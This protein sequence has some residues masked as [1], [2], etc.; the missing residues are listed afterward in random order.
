[1]ARN[2][3]L[4]PV[5]REYGPRQP[6]HS[7]TPFQSLAKPDR[8]RKCH[9]GKNPC[10]IGMSCKRCLAEGRRRPGGHCRTLSAPSGWSRELARLRHGPV[11]MSG[12]FPSGLSPAPKERRMRI[13]RTALFRG[14]FT[15]N[16]PM[17]P[18]RTDTGVKGGEKPDQRAEQNTATAVVGV[19]WSE[20]VGI[21]LGA[22]G[23]GNA[24]RA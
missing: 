13:S 16:L 2:V 7:P 9:L 17:T 3:F 23:A 14:T 21:R 6:A 24:G 11:A 4:E 20:G 8:K 18:G 15:A 10:R 1:M 12:A 22:A 5:S 19:K